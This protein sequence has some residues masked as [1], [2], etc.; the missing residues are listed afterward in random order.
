MR[1]GAHVLI[2]LT[3][4][5][6]EGE[7]DLVVLQTFSRPEI[8]CQPD[9]IV[10]PLLDEC[11]YIDMVFTVHPLLRGGLSS[12]WYHTLEELFDAMLQSFRVSTPGFSIRCGPLLTEISRYL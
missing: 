6:G 7:N 10:I 8:R 3:C 5:A 9:N 11:H 2:Q 1:D 12:P 4:K